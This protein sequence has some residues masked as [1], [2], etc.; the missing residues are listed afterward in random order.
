MT[1]HDAAPEA[2]PESGVRRFALVGN[3]NAGKSTVFNALTGMRAKVANYPGVTVSRFVGSVEVQ[4]A[5]GARIDAQ[6][7]DLPG[8]YSLDPISPDEQ[9]VLESLSDESRADALIAVL[10]ATSMR[11]SLGLIAQLQRT[12]LPI[13]V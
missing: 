1:C 10:D 11:R 13:L 12:G 4:D 7:E 5:S 3:P 9:V 2:P 8:T 6:V